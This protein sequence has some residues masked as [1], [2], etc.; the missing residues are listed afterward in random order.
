MIKIPAAL[1]YL[2]L[3]PFAQD[4]EAGRSAE[5]YRL[6]AWTV[7]SS[8]LARGAGLLLMLVSVSATVSY[9]GAERFGVWMTI[10][11]FAAILSF[12]DLGIGN[13]L[14]NRVSK[15]AS[16]NK[17][18][19]TTDLISGGL[20][21]L[22]IL[23]LLIAALLAS[24]V[25]LLPWQTIIKLKSTSITEELELALLMFAL[26]FSCSTFTNG[27]ARILSGLQRGFEVHIASLIGSLLS[28]AAILY[29]SSEEAGIPS[30]LLCSMVGPIFANLM[31][32]VRLSKQGYFSVSRSYRN[33][34]KVAPN[35]LNQGALFFLL[36]IGTMA[37]WGA[38]SL[39][40]ANT[41]GV[42]S[43]AAFAICQRLTQLISQPLLILNAPLWPAYADAY[44]RGDKAFIRT[45]FRRNFIFTLIFSSIGAVF[46]IF[47]G[48]S[49][50]QYWTGSE[51]QPDHTLIVAIAF[52]MILFDAGNSLGTLLNGIGV[53]KQQVWVVSC[54]V[55][56]AIPL[57]YYLGLSDGAAGVIFAGI[58]AYTIT[59]VF[60]YG[61]VFRSD[62][63]AK[64][65]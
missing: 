42:T 20:G 4:T 63:S 44:F 25:Q 56:L 41:A 65:R 6:I 28:L 33:T 55:L 38:D 34:L 47:S 51:V 59:T 24:A 64:I 15:A 3:R 23:T 30:L 1:S 5:R 18:N 21:V 39:I 16:E 36:Q 2:R 58:V 17:H 50:A 22:F 13:A 61:L 7:V 45:T 52:W 10:S 40:I 43:V 11:S 9:L 35:L 49:L 57:K 14:T 12:L 62:I 46:L 32:L 8:L 37:G 29:A 53:V 54:F 60:G 19:E 48:A 31:L 27:I 26:L